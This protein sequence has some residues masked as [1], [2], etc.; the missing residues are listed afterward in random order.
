MYEEHYKSKSILSV[1]SV[2]REEAR[3]WWNW[4]ASVEV[5][6]LGS[7]VVK[8]LTRTI[9]EAQKMSLQISESDG[10]GSVCV[11]WEQ[12][13]RKSIVVWDRDAEGSGTEWMGSRQIQGVTLYCVWEK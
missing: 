13:K 9:R 12:V 1:V 11:N 8:V 6:H 7:E 2:F 4:A 5:E 3:L 10:L